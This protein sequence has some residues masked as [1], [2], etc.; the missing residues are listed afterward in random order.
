MP[1]GG[2]SWSN[3]FH[4]KLWGKMWG[5]MAKRMLLTDREVANIKSEGRHSVGGNLLIQVG[6]TGKRSWLARITDSTGRRREIGLGSYPIVSL[7]TARSKVKVAREAVAKGNDPLLALHPL[8]VPSFEQLARE[9]YDGRKITFK[10]AKHRAQWIGSLETYVYPTMGRLSVDTITSAHVL[11]ALTPIWL[12][13]EET[14]RRVLQRIAKVIALAVAKGFRDHE[15]SVHGIREALPRQTRRVRHHPAIAVEDAP[16][17]YQSIGAQADG[18][19]GLVLRLIML[20]A[21]RSGEARGALWEEIDLDNAV[22]TIPASRMKAKREHRVALSREVIALLKAAA[23]FNT[24]QGL[25]FPNTKGKPLSDTAV[26]KVLKRLAPGFTVHGLRSTFKDWA[27]NETD[28]SDDVSEAA[29]AHID[30]NRV[31][32]AYKR[33]DLLEKRFSLMEDW[34]GY[35]I[36]P[37]K[38]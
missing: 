32:A 36:G 22:W 16:A 35:L 30:N 10:N 34:A 8:P 27:T 2:P 37:C 4:D 19:S 23:R 38:A 1:F 24:K 7:S 13:K 25:V 12:T 17:F 31:R 3:E 28:H 20:T 11:K 26:S 29:L 33:S 21:V 5:K 6:G 15:L 9:M 14:A 18:M